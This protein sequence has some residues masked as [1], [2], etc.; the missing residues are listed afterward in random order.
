AQ[1]E[2]VRRSFFAYLDPGPIAAFHG[3]NADLQMRQ[4][5]VVAGLFDSLA[6]RNGLLQNGRVNQRLEYDCGCARQAAGPLNDHESKGLDA[7]PV[8]PT[9]TVS[10]A[11]STTAATP[12]M[13][14]PLAFWANFT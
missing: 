6:A 13:A 2:L 10:V 1:G 4:V 7:T 11:R 8:T 14:K 5:F 3:R 9:R 12:A